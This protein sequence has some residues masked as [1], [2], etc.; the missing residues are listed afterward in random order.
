LWLRPVIQKILCGTPEER[1]GVFQEWSMGHRLLHLQSCFIS[2]TTADKEFCQRLQKALNERGVDYWYAPEHGRWGERIERQIDR[3]IAK[4]DRVILVCSEA[5]LGER[6]WIE[7][8]IE[9]AVEEEKKRGKPVIFPIMID[10]AL[11]NW[12]GPKATRIKKVLAA[13]FRGAL[14]GKAFDKAVDRLVMAL[15]SS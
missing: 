1:I 9:R 8:E 15:T 7:R 10:D 6:D 13:D 2:Y 14:D 3:E 11:D 4:R 5:S 12:R